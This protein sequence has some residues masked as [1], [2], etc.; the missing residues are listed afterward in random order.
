MGASDG[1]VSDPR[2]AARAVLSFR[3]AAGEKTHVAPGITGLTA[4]WSRC[5]PICR[6]EWL[7]SEP[8]CPGLAARRCR[9]AAERWGSSAEAGW[10]LEWEPWAGGPQPKSRFEAT[11]RKSRDHMWWA[12]MGLLPVFSVS[13]LWGSTRS[14]RGDVLGQQMKCQGGRGLCRGWGAVLCLVVEDASVIR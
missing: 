1:R 14:W 8:E 11:L 3:G 5:P 9:P 12:E 13:V 4:L 10:S 6:W 2:S 7:R